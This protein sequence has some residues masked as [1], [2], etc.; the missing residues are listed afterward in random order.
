MYRQ[1]YDTARMTSKCNAFD[2]ESNVYVCVSPKCKC[3][4]WNDSNV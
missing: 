2:N 3:S 4:I 1:S